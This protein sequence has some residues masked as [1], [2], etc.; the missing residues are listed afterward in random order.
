MGIITQNG[1]SKHQGRA[2]YI[3][4]SQ[5]LYGYHYPKQV[6]QTPKQGRMHVLHSA[7]A[8]VPVPKT[9]AGNSKAGQNACLPIRIFMGTI[10]QS[11]CSRYQGREE[12]MPCIQHIHGYHYPKRVK[13]TPRQG[14]MP[15]LYS[16]SVCKGIITQNGFCRLY[17]R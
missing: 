6:Q 1:C 8:W 10:T 16:A 14:R 3:A 13:Q 9:G 12:C 17:G 2:E 7:S 4:C 5:H 15:A 11:R